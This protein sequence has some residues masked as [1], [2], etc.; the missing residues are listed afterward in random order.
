MLGFSYLFLLEELASWRGGSSW[1][2]RVTCMIS[3]GASIDGVVVS[4]RGSG[5]TEH[6]CKLR[7]PA[8]LLIPLCHMRPLG[9]GI[10]TT[11]ES[12]GE[13][14]IAKLKSGT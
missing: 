2:V 4:Q 13:F 5:K 7:V 9:V 8:F 1:G 11:A 12:I 6:A 3:Y 14:W 10:S